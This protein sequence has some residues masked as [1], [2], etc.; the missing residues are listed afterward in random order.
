MHSIDLVTTV[1]IYHLITKS[2]GLLASQACLSIRLARLSRLPVNQA[3][4]LIKFV[5]LLQTHLQLLPRAR[6]QSIDQLGR[7]R[8][9]Q[10]N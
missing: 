10:L 8:D 2:L 9:S 6:Q 1:E 7:A 4:L 5:W 3:C